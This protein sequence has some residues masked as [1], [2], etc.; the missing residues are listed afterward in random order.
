MEKDE[1]YYRVLRC[2]AENPGWVNHIIA[3]ELSLKRR[4]VSDRAKVAREE[5]GICVSR[6]AASVTFKDY[7]HYARKCREVCGVEPLPPGAHTRLMASADGRIV[8]QRD[9]PYVRR[10]KPP[11]DT[12]DRLD[13]LLRLLRDE[14]RRQ[15]ICRVTITPDH[16]LVGRI[17][18][19]PLL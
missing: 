8:G 16:A 10:A 9:N 1:D 15:G 4:R 3:L 19:T 12:T 7:A 18:D 13:H 2:L 6:D 11:P 14:M 17:V 5:L